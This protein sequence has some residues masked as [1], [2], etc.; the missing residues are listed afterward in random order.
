MGKRRLTAWTRR[1]EAVAGRTSAG[2]GGN[3]WQTCVACEHACQHPAGRDSGGGGSGIA[4]SRLT[5]QYLA[6]CWRHCDA[7]HTCE[8]Q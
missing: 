6:L 7:P 1:A 3:A 5:F 4:A 2:S 8:H